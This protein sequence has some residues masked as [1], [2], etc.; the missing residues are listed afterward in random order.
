MSSKSKY[1]IYQNDSQY[2]NEFAENL[3]ACRKVL[4][5]SFASSEDIVSVCAP[6]KYYNFMQTSSRS[7]L[8]KINLKKEE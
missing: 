3:E 1:I 5:E 6:G 4:N 8:I 2:E 7:T